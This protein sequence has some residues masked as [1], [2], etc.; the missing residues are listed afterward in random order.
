[1]AVTISG[2]SGITYPD[3]VT[4]SQAAVLTGAIT[5]FGVSTAPSG[6]LKA[7]GAAIS[8]TT[9]SALFAVIGTTFGTGDGSTTFNVPDMRGYFARGWVDNGSVDSGRA[10][11]STQSATRVGTIQDSR[12]T[13]QPSAD[14]L[15]D[16][17]GAGA[18]TYIMSS[19]YNTNSGTQSSAVGARPINV[20][21][22]ACIKY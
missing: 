11:G 15:G 8:R 14:T 4:Q 12:T 5:F 9:Y 13:Q 20:A 6:W 18:N 21:F 3:S 17:I 22:L 7:N 2:T 10:F 16:T 1:M 19:Y